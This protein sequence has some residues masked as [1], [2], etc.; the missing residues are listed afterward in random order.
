M[1]HSIL[2]GI[3]AHFYFLKARLGDLH[4][5]FPIK[6]LSKGKDSCR[7]HKAVLLLFFFFF[8][9][10]ESEKKQGK[11]NREKP[12]SQHNTHMA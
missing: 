9:E 3:A 11:A 12:I 7:A 4:T 1:P 5:N 2:S 10:E 8:S 6:L